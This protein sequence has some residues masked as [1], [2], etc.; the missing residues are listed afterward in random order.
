M[1]LGFFLS[2][3]EVHNCSVK[4]FQ[5]LLVLCNY[6]CLRVAYIETLGTHVLCFCGTC[7][8]FVWRQ[9][10]LHCLKSRRRN[11]QSLFNVFVMEWV[12]P[13]FLAHVEIAKEMPCVGAAKHMRVNKLFFHVFGCREC[14][15][16]LCG[17]AE[18]V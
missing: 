17:C 5:A 3:G 14:T 4:I 8:K 2:L 18:C 6:L 13:F 12:V 9:G 16:P 10:G 11:L 7:S 15:L 1:N